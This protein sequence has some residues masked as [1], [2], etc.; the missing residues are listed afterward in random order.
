MDNHFENQS[1]ARRL[2]TMLN[3]DFKRM[4]TMRLFY[5]IFGICLFIPILMIVMTTMMDGTVSVNPNTGEETVIEG[6][7]YVWQIIG[8]FS[9]TEMT[10]EMDLTTMVNINLIYFIA[11]VLI[12]IFITADFRS[13]YAKNLFTVRSKRTDYVIS[14]TLLSFVC[15]ASLIIAFFIGSMLGGAMV[16]LPFDAPDGNTVNAFMCLLSKVSLV[17]VFVPIYILTSIIAKQKTWLAMMLS[18][19]AGMMLFAMIPM[20]TPLDATIVNV[21]MCLIGGLFFSIGLGAL[22]KTVLKKKDIV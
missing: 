5:I 14:K 17:L 3:V 10:M 4:F 12:C 20:L 16:G 2:K 11:A 1:F 18:F 13:G 22:S 15:G 9:D 19:F 6:L 21:F 7:D 8:I